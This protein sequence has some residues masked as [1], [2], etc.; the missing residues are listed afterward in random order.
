MKIHFFKFILLIVFIA[1]SV[2]TVNAAEEQELIAILQSSAGAVE[3]CAAA[4]QLRIYGTAQSVPAL[5]ALL[6][7]ER[8][9]HAARYALEGI[10]GP[11][12]SAALREALAKTSGLTKAG[13]IDSLG[14]RRDTESVPLLVPLISDTDAAIA[15]ATA[16]ALGRIGSNEAV[17]ALKGA[18]EN[19]NPIVRLAGAEALLGCAENRLSTGD[20]SSAAAIYSDLFGAEV[21]TAI[22]T[23]AWRGLVLSDDNQG[24]GLVV[25]A[26]SGS[27]E[28]LRLVA[29]K[30]VRETKDEQ[31][32]KACLQKWN[33]LPAMAQWA[34][35]DAH[36]QFGAEALPTIRTASKS[37]HM[38]VR[39]AAWRALVDVSDAS[40][41]PALAQAAA[42]GE[43]DERDAARDTL[44]RIHGPG[45]REALVANL[46]QADTTEKIELLVAIGKR[47]D[48]AAAPLL[49]EYANAPQETIRLAALESLRRL[50][51]AD[52]LLPLLDLI[53]ASKSASERNAIQKALSAVCKANSDKDE[54]TQQVIAAMNRQPVSEHRYVLPLLLELATDA[55]LEEMIK[56]TQSSDA[57]LVRESIRLLTQWPNAAPAEKLLEITRTNSDP[58][59]RTLALRGAITVAGREPDPSARLALIRQALSLASRAEEKKMALS[60]L[61]RI[62]LTKALEISL[63]YLENPQL[64]NEAGFAAVSI[65]ESLAEAKPQLANEASRKVLEHSKMPAIVKRA[66]AL[67][68]KPAAGGP[69][70]RD[71]LVSK[72]YRRNGVVGAIAIFDIAFGPEKPGETVKWHAAPAG[73]TINL[74]GFFPNQSDCAAYLKAEIIA[75]EATDAILLMGSDDGIKAWMNGTVVHSNNV[76]RGQ[77]VDQDMAPVKLKQGSNELLLKI[78][79]GGGGWSV[80][81]RIVGAD[82]LPIKDLHVKSQAGKAP[83]VSTYKPAPVTKKVTKQAKFPPP[84]KSPKIGEGFRLHVI[85]AKSR[86]EAAGIADMNRD[87][88]L[89]IFCGGFWYEA[90]AWKKHFVREVPE[91]GNYYYDFANLPM[92]INGNGWP[93]IA[94]C[95]WHNKKLFWLRN[96][97]STGD[98]F[99]VIDIDTPGNIETAMAVDINS[100]GQLDVLPNIMS[101]AA[102]YEYSPDKNEPHGVKWT[103]HQLPKQAATH[104]IGAGDINGD[105][106]CDIFTPNGWLEQT[107]DTSETWRWHPEFDLGHASIPILAHDVDA[108]GDAD[109]IWGMGHNY[110]LYW[111]E[112]STS[113]DNRSWQKHLID[114]SW[115]QPHFLLLADLDND[116]IDELVTGKRFHAHN[117]NDPGG[118]DPPCVYY[119]KF[120]RKEQKWQRHIIHEGGKVGLGIS[121]TALDID[122]DGDIDIVAPG[123]SGLFLLEN[124]LK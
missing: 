67:R 87:G 105:G 99:E 24:P 50:A 4:Q 95:A 77:V 53:V 58:S 32:I 71:W 34:V 12:A 21:P 73:D 3:K 102:W 92:D 39:V 42:K 15:K 40:M 14:W 35:L 86:F 62:P 79:Q 6:G 30:L 7:Q 9:G 16:S 60:Q 80:C 27:D 19:S 104:G 59:L 25:K 51:V 98:E 26:L 33:S 37:P 41:I 45:V 81:T 65:A 44:S 83:S 1:L 103:K 108:D 43:P 56:S 122:A 106:R 23:A 17:A 113:G 72:P 90:P 28:Q 75:S 82:G 11:E 46:K 22:R 31:L 18:C 114:D 112:Q 110:G 38:T 107:Q 64:V 5:A 96:P 88:K 68:V 91:Q 20:Y 66:W 13:I 109:I 36:V 8:V 74:A 93:D 89:D 52:T 48:T 97:G 49:L 119:Y 84:D 111:L 120:D 121:T 124:L 55:A 76:D 2:C 118:N 94:N 29:L 57:Q 100:D 63:Q 47:G 101:Q 117:G 70:I 78:T 123:K 69:F 116:R 61:G 10:P 85:N 115:S 54:T